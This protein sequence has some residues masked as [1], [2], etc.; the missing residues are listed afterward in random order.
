VQSVPGIDDGAHARGLLCGLLD[1]E[2]TPRGLNWARLKGADARRCDLL[3]AAADEAGCEVVL[4][5]ADVQETHEAYAADEYQGRGRY[6]QVRD[7]DEDDDGDW[8]EDED[9]GTRRLRVRALHHT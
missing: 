9:L 5:L 4:G 8:D 3:R 6:G 7:W 2:Y 1:H